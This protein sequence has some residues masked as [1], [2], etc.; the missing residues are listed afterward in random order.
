[1]EQQVKAILDDIPGAIK[2]IEAGFN[3]HP[4]RIDFANGAASSTQSVNTLGANSGAAANPFQK[5]STTANPF[6]NATA[7]VSAFGQVS[8]PGFGQPAFGQSSVSGQTNSSFGQ[9]SNPGQSASPFG[10]ALA[11]GSKPSPFGQPSALGGA[12]GFG[13]PAFGASGFGQPSMP[14]ASSAFVPSNVT[15]QPSTFGQPSAPGPTSGFGQANALGQKPNPFAKPGFGQSGFG[16]PAQPGATASPFGQPAQSGASPFGQSAQPS[17]GQQAAPPQSP[18]G[19]PA[20]SYQATNLFQ[21]G[22]TEAP[23]DKVSPFANATSQPSLFGQPSRP[24]AFGTQPSQN[25]AAQPANPFL[26]P[27][28]LTTAPITGPSGTDT[29]NQAAVSITHTQTQPQRPASGYAPQANTSANANIDPKERFKEGKPQEY[30]G[31]QGKKLEDIYKRVAQ[32]GRFNENED[33]PLTPPKCEWIV[34]MPA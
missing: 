16:Q 17:F 3:V 19:Q 29:Q 5:A 27:P 34:P 15:G 30:D 13:K 23:G 4:N 26:N 32:L 24:S 21:Q 9:P 6:S 22:R 31:E 7:P 12:G 8:K 33:I 11:L 25:N 14:G 1:M 18:F 2:Y 20:Q 10:A 28:S